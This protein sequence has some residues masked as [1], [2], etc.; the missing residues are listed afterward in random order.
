MARMK[1][2]KAGPPEQKWL[3]TYADMVTLLM[4]FFVLL[5]ALSDVDED[6]LAALAEAFAA[7]VGFFPGALGQIFSDGAGFM[8]ENAPPVPLTMD[9]DAPEVEDIEPDEIVEIVHARMG[10]MEAMAESFR[11]Y[12]APYALAQNVGISIDELGEFIRI[13]FESGMLFD[14]GQATLL[15]DAIEMIDYV[16]THLH[17]FPGHRIAI[18]GHTDNVPISTIQFPSNM[19]LASAR[20][21]AVHQRLVEFHGFDPWLVEAVGLG[22]Y[23]PVATNDTIEGRANNRRVEVLVFA[24]QQDIQVIM[25]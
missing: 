10:Q 2:P 18:H 7:R 5:Y 24:N 16:A 12:M 25:D 3:A 13:T 15:P 20:A 14:S 8:P 21:I 17:R 9:P 4:C 6:A 19:H 1:K 11:T 22:E 23:R